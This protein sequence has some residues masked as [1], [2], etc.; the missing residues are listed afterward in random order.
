MADLKFLAEEW[1]VIS[2]RLDEGLLLAPEQ[3]DT[4]LAALGETDSVKEKLR[5]LLADAVGVETDDFLG[6]L[7]KLTLN[8]GEGDDESTA[9]GA[10][11]G[12]VIGP[13]QLI[14]ELGVGGMGSVW[15]SER[16]DGGLKRQVALKLP[17]MSWS[18][19]LAARMSRERDILASLDHP[20]IARIYDAGLDEHGRP[21]LALEYVE[22]EPIDVHC[23]RRALSVR[24][25]LLLLL[26][27]ARAVA[28]AHAR[29]VVHRDLKPANILVTSAGEVRLLD[30][31]IAK[32]IDGEFTQETK[33]TR[34]SGRA[35]TLD[36]ASPEQIRGEPIGTASDVYSLGVVAYELLTEAKPYQFKRQ[37]A[38]ALEEAIASVDVRLASIASTNPVTRRALTG[39]LDAILNKALKKNVTERYPT[40]EAFAQDVERHLANLP[41][42]AQPDALTYRATK[43]VRRNRFALAATTAAMVVVIAA[44]AGI[45]WQAIVARQQRDFAVSQLDRAEAT[46]GFLR[47]LLHEVSPSGKPF[48]TASLLDQGERMVQKAFPDNAVQ[49]VE[50]LLVLAEQN[51]SLMRT[52]QA[53]TLLT[54]AYETSLTIE[55]PGLRARSACMF[56]HQTARAGRHE[57]ATRIVERALN[58]LPSTPTHA[59]A[60]MHCL[61]EAVSIAQVREQSDRAIAYGQE[62]TRLAEQQAVSP[63]V[64]QEAHVSLADALRGAERHT[65]ADA[66]YRVGEQILIAMGKEKTLPMIA[67]LNNWGISVSAL[68]RPRD[69]EAIYARAIAVARGINDNGEL[70]AYLNSSYGHVLLALARNADAAVAFQDAIDTGQRRGDK[71]NVV[72]SQMGLSAA[73]IELGRL[74]EAERAQSIVQASLTELLPR[75]HFGW[76]AFLGYRARLAFARKNFAEALRLSDESIAGQIKGTRSPLVAF[77]VVLL[78]ASIL[79]AMNRPEEANAGV[80]QALEIAQ[81]IRSD[82]S[83]SFSLGKCHLLAGKIGLALNDHAGAKK[84]LQLALIQIEATTSGE[85]PLAQQAHALLAL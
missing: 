73:Y 12:T 46:T 61:G 21:Y 3:R 78:R 18:Q 29:L 40:V 45:T 9:Y 27:V 70:P 10:T 69:A 2:R 51:I 11:V 47:S 14:R 63:A 79:L 55:N 5:H 85:H 20:N 56:A 7:P 64:R 66:Q 41:V 59:R 28:H 62:L 76:S 25:R 48:T 42:M 16:I 31:G 50:V 44:V 30:F 37:S 83:P 65:E 80:Q 6:S 71:L 13:Y 8:R 53:L 1:P 24:D 74:D 43:F 17:R 52:T 84:S 81:R 67:L 72:K 35:L 23:K 38:A 49:R 60:R 34:Q 82:D 54:Q 75:G 4:W 39:D 57:E 19:G 15:L 77:P 68:G 58:E 32:L 26:Q 36:Y 22:G 33:L